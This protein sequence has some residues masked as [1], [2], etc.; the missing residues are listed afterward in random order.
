[1]YY[2]VYLLATYR[3]PEDVYVGY[4][5]SIVRRFKEHTNPNK[6]KGYTAGKKW[7]VVCYLHGLPDIKTARAFEDRFKKP[8]P[9][10]KSPLRRN[11]KIKELCAM[12]YMERV[13]PN[14]TKT[15]QL[16]LSLHWPNK[17]YYDSI[18]KETI[19]EG[20]M[21]QWPDYIRHVF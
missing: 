19:A 18:V 10:A 13:K 8:K 7:R 14:I 6:K 12:L 15:K 16:N 9:R 21:I 3:G 4:T 20:C 2:S 17:M 11:R 5:C 1:M